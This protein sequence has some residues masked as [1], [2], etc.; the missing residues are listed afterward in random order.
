MCVTVI[1]DLCGDVCT[2]P[3]VIYLPGL[4]Q[5]KAMVLSERMSE[6]MREENSLRFTEVCHHVGSIL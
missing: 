1:S 2:G 3:S 6:L 4:P 5:C